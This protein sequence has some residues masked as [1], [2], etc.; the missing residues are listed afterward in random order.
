MTLAEPQTRP[1]PRR[2]DALYKTE[3]EI[4]AMVGLGPA[5]WQ[6]VAAELERQG[7]P[8]RDPLFLHRRYWPAVKAFLDRRHGLLHDAV[9]AA[10]DGRENWDGYQ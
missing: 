2:A 8:L 3:A 1:R 10:A 5:E 7:L 4:A 6:R 9:P